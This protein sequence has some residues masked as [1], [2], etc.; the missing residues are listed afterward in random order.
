MPR[1]MFDIDFQ[2]LSKTHCTGKLQIATLGGSVRR[3]DVEE[4]IREDYKAKKDAGKYN[5]PTYKDHIQPVTSI[6]SAMRADF[7]QKTSDWNGKGGERLIPNVLLDKI[8]SFIDEMS[9][10]SQRVLEEQLS[11]YDEYKDRA[12]DELGDLFREEDWPTADA[13]RKRHSIVF[14]Q[15]IV[16][17][18][19]Q[20]V[21]AGVSPDQK[22]RIKNS[23]KK[24]IAENVKTAKEDLAKQMSETVKKVR[25]GLK[26]YKGTKESSF[27]NSLIGN[28]RDMS[29]IVSQLNPN[30]KE[31][32]DTIIDIMNTLS[33]L[34]PEDLRQD[35]VKRKKAVEDA[36]NI[37]N[38]IGSFGSS[39]N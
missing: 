10:E 15:G 12:R 25:D 1:E 6:H 4:K 33:V 26:N 35:D 21:R 36:N 34:D 31:I 7:K 18:P 2:N 14:R 32:E 24:Q 39:L 20:D 19:D 23:V 22:E 29:T 28:V 38:N 8:T 3:E 5:L 13:I 27:R 16:P 37:L 17:D 30:D 9:I 11:T